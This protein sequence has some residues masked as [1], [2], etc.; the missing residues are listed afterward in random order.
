MEL[1][2]SIWVEVWKN[3]EY[4]LKWLNTAGNIF[5][6]EYIIAAHQLDTFLLREPKFIFII[7]LLLG[8]ISI[9]TILYI[10][11]SIARAQKDRLETLFRFKWLAACFWIKNYPW[12]LEEGI[13]KY[14]QIPFASAESIL[15]KW[16]RNLVAILQLQFCSKNLQNSNLFKWWT[17]FFYCLRNY[18]WLEFFVSPITYIFYTDIYVHISKI[19]P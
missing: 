14:F 10:Y 1:E 16:T 4:S 8:S 3:L 17:I 7:S 11:W 19:L 2:N 12:S 5:R 9:N 15:E 18:Y 6:W 13:G